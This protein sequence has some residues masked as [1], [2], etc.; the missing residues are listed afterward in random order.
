MLHDAA[1]AGM[2]REDAEALA[3]PALG[4]T[5]QDEKRSQRLL[6]LSGLT[7]DQLRAGLG[8]PAVL[9]AVLEFL[10]NHE[11]DLLAASEAL[12][13]KPDTL[14]AAQHTLSGTTPP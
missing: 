12:G 10:A 3:L 14:I 13:V 8:D 6:T 5:L 9:G 11:P 7:P 1:R 2:T 4:W